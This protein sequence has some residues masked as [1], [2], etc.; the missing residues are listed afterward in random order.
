MDGNASHDEVVFTEHLVDPDH[1]RKAAW[2]RQRFD[3][4]FRASVVILG[5]LAALAGIALAS[6]L[7][8]EISPAQVK[9]AQLVLG[10]TGLLMLYASLGLAALYMLKISDF[11]DIYASPL[12]EWARRFLQKHPRFKWIPSALASLALML[13]LAA[14]AGYPIAMP[15]VI[16][17]AFI[18]LMPRLNDEVRCEAEYWRSVQEETYRPAKDCRDIIAR[19]KGEGAE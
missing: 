14:S 13:S 16:G 7:G 1:E 5:G 6:L 3:D 12:R 15:L 4:F 19:M 2:W 11:C 17:G 10:Q 8:G 9:Y 18:G